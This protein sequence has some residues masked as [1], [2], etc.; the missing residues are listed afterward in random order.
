MPHLLQ[1]CGAA[2][3]QY[4]ALI[5]CND[6]SQS[7]KIDISS[8][9]EQERIVDYLTAKRLGTIRMMRQVLDDDFIVLP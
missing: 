7:I 9:I 5:F 3:E 2:E 8:V 6:S 1:D 4:L